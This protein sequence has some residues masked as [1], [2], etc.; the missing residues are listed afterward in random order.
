MILADTRYKSV[1]GWEHTKFGVPGPS[2]WSCESRA[3]EKFGREL[4]IWESYAQFNQ[5]KWMTAQEGA[6]SKKEKIKYRAQVNSHFFL[7]I[8]TEETAKKE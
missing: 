4:W 1:K 3:Q 6:K 2:R 5:G 8:K 7:R